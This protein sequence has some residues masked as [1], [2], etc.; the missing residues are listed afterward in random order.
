MHKF[1]HGSRC[2]NCGKKLTKKEKMVEGGL[3]SECRGLDQEWNH[4][5]KDNMPPSEED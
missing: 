1:L 2:R 4:N 3:C 5:A